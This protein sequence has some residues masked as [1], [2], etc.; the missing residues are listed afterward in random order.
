M[1]QLSNLQIW[2]A[3]GVFE[4]AESISTLKNP[5]K[6][7]LKSYFASMISLDFEQKLVVRAKSLNV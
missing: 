7:L 3:M 2:G 1:L 5:I 4:G 6:T